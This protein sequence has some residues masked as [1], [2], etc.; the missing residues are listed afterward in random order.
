VLRVEPLDLGTGVTM[1]F[2]SFSVLVAVEKALR[3]P[4]GQLSLRRSTMV[5]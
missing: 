5:R 1:A 2:V 4:N 3:E